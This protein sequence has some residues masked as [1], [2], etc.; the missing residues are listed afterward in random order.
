VLAHEHRTADQLTAQGKPLKDPEC[1]QTGRRQPADH[2]VGR[3][4]AHQK[5]RHRHC[6][7]SENEKFFAPDAVGEMRDDHARDR[8]HEIADG[9]DAE[10]LHL[11]FPDR[12][13]RRKQRRAKRDGDKDIDLEIEKFQ[14]RAHGSEADVLD[15]LHTRMHCHVFLPSP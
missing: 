5:G 3:Q 12:G 4:A 9:E 15:I 8:P 10:R 6:Q 7:N 2:R 14:N 13:V 1:Q 11:I